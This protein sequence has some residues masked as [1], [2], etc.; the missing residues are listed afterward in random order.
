MALLV[1]PQSEL[2]RGLRPLPSGVVG[3]WYPAPQGWIDVSQFGS[4]I[5][6]TSRS[7][8]V[9][10]LPLPGRLNVSLNQGIIGIARASPPLFSTSG[11]A[12]SFWSKREAGSFYNTLLA[13]GGT[14][15]WDICGLGNA[16]TY[17]RNGAVIYTGIGIEDDNYHCYTITGDATGRAWYVDDAVQKSDGTALTVRNANGSLWARYRQGGG[18][19][20]CSSPLGP[21]VIFSRAITLAEHTQFWK[22]PRCYLLGEM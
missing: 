3:A 14:E 18:T 20:V 16:F 13:R 12:C 15:D 11:F 19:T 6:E 2:I 5:R 10:L 8:S 17:T 22:N 7:G 1:H 9:G 4:D 21:F